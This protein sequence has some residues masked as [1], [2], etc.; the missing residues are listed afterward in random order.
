LTNTIQSIQNILGSP[1]W[2]FVWKLLL[3]A[4]GMLWLTLVLWTFKDA[5]KRIDDWLIIIVAVATSIVFPFIGT[6][7]YA[8][9]RPH[10]YLADARE[11]ELEVEAMEQDLRFVRN[12]PSCREPV[13][14]DYLVC[15]NCRRNLRLICPSCGRPV[16]HNWK[17]CP[18]C[19]LDLE[20]RRPAAPVGHV[21]VLP[22][23][24][25]AGAVGSAGRTSA[26]TEQATQLLES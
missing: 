10:E 24:A 9:L 3:F 5:R 12:C 8:I 17:A 26:T 22:G 11:R 13:R 19:G 15:P 18:Y 16:E 6:L 25:T 4:M 14:D 21:S 7:V 20:M 1:V 23:P 2:G